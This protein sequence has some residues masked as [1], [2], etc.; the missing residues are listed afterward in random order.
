MPELPEVETVVRNIRPNIIG[1][2]ISP[3]KTILDDV[4]GKSATFSLKD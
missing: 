1:K 4:D 3:N 2:I